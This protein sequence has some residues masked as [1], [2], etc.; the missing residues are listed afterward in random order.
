[1]DFLLPP[2]SLNTTARDDEDVEAAEGDEEVDKGEV[3]AAIVAAAVAACV[4]AAA[5][6]AGRLRTRCDKGTSPGLR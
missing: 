4:A 1:L 6:A 5:A 2:P 3:V